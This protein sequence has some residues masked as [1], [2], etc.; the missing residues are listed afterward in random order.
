L[1]PPKRRLMLW[2]SRMTSP[3]FFVMRRLSLV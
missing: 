1:T 2:T 3:I